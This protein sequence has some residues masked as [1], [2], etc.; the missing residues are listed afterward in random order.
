MGILKEILEL[1]DGTIKGI[2]RDS[3][4]PFIKLKLTIRF[5]DDMKVEFLIVKL[6]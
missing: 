5:E 4:Y 2:T 3:A 6:G 1:V